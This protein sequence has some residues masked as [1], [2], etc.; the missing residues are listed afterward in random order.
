MKPLKKVL[1]GNYTLK[2]LTLPNLLSF[3]NPEDLE[4]ITDA[5]PGYEIAAK[6]NLTVAT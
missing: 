6:G 3:L 5:I 1:E 2:N 4:V